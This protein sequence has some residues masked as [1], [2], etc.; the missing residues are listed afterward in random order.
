[1]RNKNTKISKEAQNSHIAT[2]KNLGENL[3]HSWGRWGGGWVLS[4]GNG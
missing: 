3:Q 4:I 2:K 1:L